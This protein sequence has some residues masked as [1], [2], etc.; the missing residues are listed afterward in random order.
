MQKK[1]S[2]DNSVQ[3][4]GKSFSDTN[5]VMSYDFINLINVDVDV[6]KQA[7]LQPSVKLY[8]STSCIFNQFRDKLRNKALKNTRPSIK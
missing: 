8:I 3:A 2:S 1:Q 5:D 4:F 6:E 7:I